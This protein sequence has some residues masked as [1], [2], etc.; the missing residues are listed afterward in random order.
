[1]VRRWLRIF[2]VCLVLS[3]LTAFPLRAETGWLAA[4][5]HHLPTPPPLLSWIERIRT[6]VADTDARYPFLAYGTD[7]LAFAHLVIAGAFW[8]PL[9]DPVRNVWV[10]Q[11][12][13]GACAGIIPLALLCGPVRGI[14]FFWSCVDMS[15][16][17]LGA[18]P[19]L[20]VLRGIRRLEA[21]VQGSGGRP[22]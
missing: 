11:W 18:I 2:V 7:W 6:G 17:V 4:A 5:A 16:G 13:L 19:L 12:A 15:F 3:G 9:R 21:T 14:P 22:W 1:M 20:I 10:I 8:G